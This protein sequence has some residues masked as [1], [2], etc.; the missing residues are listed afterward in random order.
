M[1]VIIVF[2][3]KA[4]RL[5][6]HNVSTCMN[7]ALDNSNTCIGYKLA[8]YRYMYNIDMYSD[9]NSSIKLL[10]ASNISVMNRL[11]S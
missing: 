1:F 11:Q 2:L 4:F 7:M 5:R 10:S 6:N 3:W 9:I 8:F